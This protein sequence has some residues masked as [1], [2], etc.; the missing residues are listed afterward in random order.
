[1]SKAKWGVLGV[2][3]GAVAGV[4]FAPKSGKET[5]KDIKDGAVKAKT[6]VSKRAGNAKKEATKKVD[7]ATGAAE[8]VADKAARAAK[9]GVAAA[10]EELDK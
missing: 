1:M 10:K 5:R 9:K 6:E 7:E 3:V 4:L 2:V 8:K